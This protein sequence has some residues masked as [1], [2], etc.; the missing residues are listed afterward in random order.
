MLLL[1]NYQEATMTD[2]Q[3]KYKAIGYLSFV[4]SKKTENV[5]DSQH[6]LYTSRDVVGAYISGYKKSLNDSLKWNNP[7]QPPTHSA[8]VIC[9]VLAPNCT[10]RVLR[11]DNNKWYENVRY[12]SDEQCGWEE[13]KGNVCAWREIIV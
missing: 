5:I 11:Y 9:M 3:I 10:F 6:S 7:K 4:K 12:A 8:E 2:E 1:N 13:F